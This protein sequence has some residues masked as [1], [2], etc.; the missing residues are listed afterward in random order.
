MKKCVL[1]AL[2][3]ILNGCV[4]PSFKLPNGF[5]RFYQAENLRPEM[6]RRLI[7]SVGPP[8]IE[9]VPLSQLS[10]TQR[11]YGE[12]GYIRIGSA[13]FSGPPASREDAIEQGTLVGAQFVLIGSTYARTAQGVLPSLSVQPGQTF[14]TQ[15]HGNVTT[16]AFPGNSTSVGTYSGYSTTTTAPTLQ[17]QYTPYEIPIHDQVATFWKLARPP[18][19]GV[20]V[21]AL[22]D[23]VRSKLER[24]TGVYVTGVTEGSPA[25]LANILRGDVIV[26]IG[27]VPIESMD[28]FFEALHLMQGQQVIVRV[29]RGTES[30]EIEVHLNQEL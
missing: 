24:N 18:I 15:A 27:K 20:S 1:I 4:A 9:M 7:P 12:R 26:Q 13:S 21:G 25:F 30:R 11:R 10:D 3:I 22:P 2:A 14:T 19:L 5:A 16:G 29:L 28:D 17:T 8:E 23:E 6:Q